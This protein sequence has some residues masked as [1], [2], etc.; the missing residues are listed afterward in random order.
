ML[1]HACEVGTLYSNLAEAAEAES[2]YGRALK[3]HPDRRELAFDRL[4][5][6]RTRSA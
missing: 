6:R 1:Q 2:M 4:D 5:D 3:I